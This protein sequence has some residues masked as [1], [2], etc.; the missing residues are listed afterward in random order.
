MPLPQHDA[1]PNDVMNARFESVVQGREYI[2][3]YVQCQLLEKCSDDSEVRSLLIYLSVTKEIKLAEIIGAIKQ[4]DGQL[5]RTLRRQES[6]R[7]QA[8]TA[9]AANLQPV[10][11][12]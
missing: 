8:Q 11:S 9:A 12:A 4:I 6:E 7:Y 2:S 1:S 5:A 10:F 3:T